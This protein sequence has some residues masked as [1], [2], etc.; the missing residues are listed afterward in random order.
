[1]RNWDAEEE[2]SDSEIKS[3]PIY[4]A[5]ERCGE[6]GKRA[7]AQVRALGEG[8]SGVREEVINGCIDRWD[9]N[10]VCAGQCQ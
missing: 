3:S 1:M 7:W 4:D 9:R 10:A 8:M 5:E 2:H 6:R